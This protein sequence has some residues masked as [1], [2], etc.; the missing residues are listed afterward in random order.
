VVYAVI[1]IAAMLL[2]SIARTRWSKLR[3]TDL[4]R[5]YFAVNNPRRVSGD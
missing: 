5:A 1:L 4:L 2:L 3:I